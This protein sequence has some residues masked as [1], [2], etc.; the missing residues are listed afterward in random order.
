MLT[1]LQLGVF[2]FLGT[3]EVKRNGQLNAGLLDMELA[4]QWVQSYIHLFG[5][6]PRKV[7]I[8]G[9]SAGGGA[10]MLMSL[11]RGGR[12]G[13]SLFD[14]VR[15]RVVQSPKQRDNLKANVYLGHCFKSL[16]AKTV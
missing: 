5:G 2:G 12:L 13:D 7:T 8:A 6:N 16:L 4:L 1:R 14:Q 10:V 3:E 9:E 15:I 11:L